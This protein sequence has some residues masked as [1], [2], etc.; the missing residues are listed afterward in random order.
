[1]GSRHLVNRRRLLRQAAWAATAMLPAAWS[2]AAEPAGV[3]E[4]VRGE[5]FA[6]AGSVH[7]TLAQA[8]P[9]FLNDEVGTG[10]DSRLGMR[11]GRNTMLRL[12]EDARVKIDRFLVD[13]GGEITLE[14]GPLLFDRPRSQRPDSTRIR[15]PFGLIAVRGTRLFAGPSNARFGVFVER[16]IVAVTARGRQVVLHAGEGTDFDAPG[17][18]PTPAKPWLPPRIRAAF[19]S[20][21]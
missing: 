15:T 16:G 1:M 11:L 2:N 13:A 5:A 20:V 3:V 12:G 10:H 19:A 7:R 8:A 18:A 6:E 21:E 9:L 4:D 14:S 17:A